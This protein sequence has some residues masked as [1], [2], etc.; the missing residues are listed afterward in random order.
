MPFFVSLE[1]EISKAQSAGKSLIIELDA[2]SKLGSKYIKNDPKPMSPNGLI[3][4]GII[5]RHALTVANGVEGR[6]HGVVTRRRNT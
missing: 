3:L 5:D 4:S 1:E 2:N 6:S